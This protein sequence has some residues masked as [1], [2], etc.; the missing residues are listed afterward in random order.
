MKIINTTILSLL[1][2]F[3][4]SCEDITKESEKAYLPKARGKAGVILIVMD[5][6][7]YNAELG[8][9]LRKILAEPILGL[10]QP[11]P[12]FTIKNINPLKF[13]SL[14]KAAKNLI[15]VTTLDG[16]SRQNQ[17]QLKHFT[18][19]SLNKIK[20]DPSLY[21]F[22]KKDDFAKGQAILHLF[23]KDDES[24]KEKIIEN[25][26]KIRN[27]FMQIENKR[28]VNR[29]FKSEEK[30][31]KKI[32]IEEHDFSLRIPF[33]FELAKN[34]KDFVWIR[35][36]DKEIEKNIFAYYRPFTS[37]EPFN[38]PLEY[39]ESITTEYMRDSQK[40][41]IF[42]TL[43]QVPSTTR[44][45]TFH[46]KYAKQTRGLWK[47]SDISGGGSFISYVFVDESQKRIYYLEGYVYAPGK[48]KREPMREVELIL[49]TFKSGEALESK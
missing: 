32:L 35:Q 43:Q 18:N 19:E 41:D 4:F 42:M 31:V 27:H 13:N 2:L 49:S 8:L 47:L 23:G 6:A 37:Q 25:G 46:G 26:L 5:T 44:E 29:I 34:E 14:L 24:L 22:K 3:N 38:D 39:R 45:V 15:F 36:M 7:K 16:G 28:L 1:L 40:P 11:E 48:D 33:G 20:N 9:A 30:G 21:M 10:P 12:Y 17:S